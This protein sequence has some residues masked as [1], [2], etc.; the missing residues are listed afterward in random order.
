[1]SRLWSLAAVA[2][3]AAVAVS[4]AAAAQHQRTRWSRAGLY[5]AIGAFTDTEVHLGTR[6]L[7]HRADSGGVYRT[8]DGY[9]VRVYV[10][11]SYPADPATDQAAVNFLD[12]LVH[13]PELGNLTV[14][15]KTP[16]EIGTVCG[17]DALACYDPTQQALIVP[18][19]DVPG[20]AVE[21][22][23]AH[24]YGHHVARNRNNAPWLAYTYG[25][26][27][28]ASY[29]GICTLAQHGVVFPGD[30]G[31]HYALNPG[32]AFAETYRVL[33]TNA[34]GFPMLPWNI[35][36]NGFYP[37]TTDLDLVREDVLQPWTS[38]TSYVWRGTFRRR[39]QLLLKSLPSYY[40]GTVAVSVKGPRGTTVGLVDKQNHVV[41][42]TR[43]RLAATLCSGGA[44]A[45]V[46]AGRRGRFTVTVTLP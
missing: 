31:V 22:I 19:E 26:K 21:P 16:S 36:D 9:S 11:P 40:D 23:V 30:E 46:L 38:P 12:S 42:A 35:V 43:T 8:A 45:A 29:E 37:D 44:R 20:Y 27:R 17:A 32:E 33:N 7:A 13:G 6:V 5:A 14:Y 10:S 2:V 15:V 18:G 39:R 24:E 25:T 1:M 28:W 34:L 3:A 41:A 4:G